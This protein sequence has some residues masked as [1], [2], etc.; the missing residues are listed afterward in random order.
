MTAVRRSVRLAKKPSFPAVEHAQR[1]L[2]CKLGISTDE[3]APIE[4]VLQDFIGMF[5][6]P[7]PEHIVVAM[8]AIF[9]LN[10]DD[11]DALDEALLQHAG[12]SVTELTPIED[13]ASA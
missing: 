11:V 7:L 4:E 3:M 6:G 10:D 2:W 9:N 1:N 5:R 12:T 8:M 13:A